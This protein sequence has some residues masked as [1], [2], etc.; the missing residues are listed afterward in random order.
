[1]VAIWPVSRREKPDREDR[2]GVMAKEKETCCNIDLRN[3]P[4]NL[5]A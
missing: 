1:M 4:R 2:A 3:L 5:E